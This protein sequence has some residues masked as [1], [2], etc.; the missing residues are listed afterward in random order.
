[1]KIGIYRITLT[2]SNG[3]SSNYV[4]QSHDVKQRLRSHRYQLSHNVHANAHLLSAW[5]KYGPEAFEF[6]LLEETTTDRLTERETWWI[7][8]L[9]A[10][11]SQGGFN[12]RI[13]SDSNRGLKKSPEAVRRSNAH[14]KGVPLSPEHKAAIGE[15]NRGRQPSEQCIA[16]ALEV[17]KGKPGPMTGRRHTEA[18]KQKI[19]LTKRG[20]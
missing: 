18:T 17:R 11:H 5:K 4:G 3:V 15:A 6:A 19:S 13:A 14:R 16:K 7:S 9:K 12:Q 1:M 2:R 10:H 8:E 20:S